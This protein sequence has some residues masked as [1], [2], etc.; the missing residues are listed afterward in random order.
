LGF[1][2]FSKNVCIKIRFV[3]W[4]DLKPSKVNYSW[5]QDPL[6]WVYSFL[7]LIP[8]IMVFFYYN[9]YKLNL[10]VYAGWSLLVFSIILIL[11]A[12]YEFKKYGGAPEGESV[13]QTTVLVDS[14]IY[15]IVRH[16]QYLGFNLFVR[17]YARSI[18]IIK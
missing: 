1:P 5:K 4:S 12:G 2:T 6:L 17:A 16:P 8:V 15:S 11:L 13:V 3:K 14:G 9:Y 18:L 10:C 7:M